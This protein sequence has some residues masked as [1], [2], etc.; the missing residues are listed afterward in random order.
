[1]IT[2]SRDIVR[3]IQKELKLPKEERDGLIGKDTDQAIK[4]YLMVNKQKLD[5]QYAEKILIAGRKRKAVTFGQL[6]AIERGIEIGKVDGFI[7]P[8]TNVGL[9]NLIYL[10]K[11]GRLPHPFRDHEIPNAKRWPVEGS[12]EFKEFYGK[13]GTNMVK[14]DAPY[15]FKIAWMPSS[16]RNSFDC[17]RKV[18]DSLGIVLSNVRREYGLKGISE[19]GLDLWGGC[20]NKRKKRGGTSWSMHSWANALDYHPVKNQLNMTTTQALFSRPDYDM[21]WKFW[22][23]E[24]WVGLGRV[25][26]YDWM[27][28]QAARLKG[29]D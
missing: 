2:L 11:Y 17:H 13:A 24:G 19:L 28:I 4:N 23:D 22:E 10:I 12:L 26:G 15:P 21:W 27:H 6:I 3:L 25:R 18:A 8:Q 7:G 29:M 1:M 5:P 14:F 16:P 9:E 20:Y